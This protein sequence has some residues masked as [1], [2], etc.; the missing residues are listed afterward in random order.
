MVVPA[1]PFSKSEKVNLE[2]LKANM[3][4]LVEK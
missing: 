4:Y 1:T 3:E 2:V